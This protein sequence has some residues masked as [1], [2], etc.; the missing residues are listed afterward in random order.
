[1]ALSFQNSSLKPTNKFCPNKV[2]TAV[3]CGLSTKL[4]RKP[5]GMM[6]IMPPSNMILAK[7]Q[8]GSG[9]KRS[10]RRISQNQKPVLNNSA[11]NTIEVAI[12]L[13]LLVVV[14]RHI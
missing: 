14:V 2:A 6:L 3:A 7:N 13:S 12:K 1:M 11:V 8:N 9:A 10:L 4:L 5:A